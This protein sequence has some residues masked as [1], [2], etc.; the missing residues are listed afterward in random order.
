MKFI[1]VFLSL[2]S[3][4]LIVLSALLI[5]Y[6]ALTAVNRPSK[7]AT[8]ETVEDAVRNPRIGGKTS[9]Q[10]FQNRQ[11]G[12][13]FEPPTVLETSPVPGQVITISNT[14]IVT[15]SREDKGSAAA[16][17]LLFDRRATVL[18]R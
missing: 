17:Q 3:I 8:E 2:H 14:M 10:L 18:D 7:A 6:L 12:I 15:E 13:I 16:D 11:I 9:G 5:T 4:Q 1:R